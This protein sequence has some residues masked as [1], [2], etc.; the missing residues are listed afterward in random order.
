MNPRSNVGN[1][2]DPA[3]SIADPPSN[4]QRPP[5]PLGAVNPTTH[6]PS[7]LIL[8]IERSHVT[9]F[10]G[11]QTSKEV[12]RRIVPPLGHRSMVDVTHPGRLRRTAGQDRGRGEGG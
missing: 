2:P 6:S 7:G 1:Q 3:R 9:S 10:A 12:G 4:V 8:S 5:C 11:I